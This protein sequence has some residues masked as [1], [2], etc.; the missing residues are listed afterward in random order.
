MPLAECEA[1]VVGKVM[2][3]CGPADVPLS[4]AELVDRCHAGIAMLDQW[5]KGGGGTLSY[6]GEGHR[7]P[8]NR[9]R[10]PRRPSKTTR[11]REP[12]DRPQRS[13]RLPADGADAAGA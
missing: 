11:R 12:A 13:K 9:H 10:G 6:A 1:W 8:K 2:A 5:A 3:L 7:P 4:E